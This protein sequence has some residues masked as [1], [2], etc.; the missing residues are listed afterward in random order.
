MRDTALRALFDW[1][2]VSPRNG[3][4]PLAWR[5]VAKTTRQLAHGV[6]E[7]IKLAGLVGGH[8]LSKRSIA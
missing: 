4:T 7:N 3:S 6:H 5:E 8:R 2:Y 1:H